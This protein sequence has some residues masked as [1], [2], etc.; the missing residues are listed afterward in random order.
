MAQILGIDKNSRV[1]DVATGSVGFLISCM[2]LMI[3]QVNQ[4][5]G[6]GTTSANEKIEA[7]KN[8]R[9]MGI[10]RD[11]QMYTLAATNMI[12]RGDG[13]AKI[14]KGS[15]F[16][17]PKKLY[18]DFGATVLLL[19]P[20]FTYSENGMPFLALGLKYMEKGYFRSDLHKVNLYCLPCLTA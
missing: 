15:S 17:Q 1:L 18:E 19:N 16:D 6:K 14:E 12:M 10:E 4:E 3:E 13:S 20:P 5:H 9:F 2:E 11:S 8:I 7:I